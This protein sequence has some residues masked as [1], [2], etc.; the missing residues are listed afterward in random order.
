MQDT[1][2][3]TATLLVKLHEKASYERDLSGE[4]FTIGRRPDNDLVID[5]AAV[6][7]H[8]ARISK[9]HAVYFVEDLKSTNGTWVNDK[10]IDRH[11]LRDTDVLT[12]GRHRLIF[13]DRSAAP[14]TGDAPSEEVDQ[15]VILTGRAARRDTMPPPASLRVLSGKTDQREY[16]LLKH[17]TTIGSQAQA[18][19][20]L[21]GWFAPASAALITRRQSSY[22]VSNPRRGKP[23]LVNGEQVA[24]EREL[25]DHDR[26]E[27]AGTTLLFRLKT[28]RAA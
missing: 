20:R 16:L 8:H 17:I 12:I 14:L 13:R 24:A 2:T 1:T 23:L 4:C 19:V 15:T 28:E 3:R 22:F 26:I 6:S 27:V 7:G 21:T 11:Q 25:K 9:I 10:R 5:D 18:G